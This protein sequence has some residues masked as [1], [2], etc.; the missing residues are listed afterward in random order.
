MT[1]LGARASS[2]FGAEPDI[3]AWADGVALNPVRTPP[4]ERSARL[5]EALHRLQANMGSGVARLAE[6]AGVS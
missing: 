4:G 6:L 1:V 3:K 2:S 5:V